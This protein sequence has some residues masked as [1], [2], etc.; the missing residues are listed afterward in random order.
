[1]LPLQTL[2]GVDLETKLYALP[3]C[4]AKEEKNGGKGKNK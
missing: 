3:T 2:R 4:S 1:M